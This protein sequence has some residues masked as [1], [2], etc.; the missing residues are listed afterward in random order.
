[1]EA[2]GVEC[3]AGQAGSTRLDA[4]GEGIS[5]VAGTGSVGV[6]RASEGRAR[7]LA[8]VMR[9]ALEKLEAGDVETAKVLLRLAG[10]A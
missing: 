2:P 4:G 3:G 8:T 10:G 1:M 6:E 7:E 5:G 9:V